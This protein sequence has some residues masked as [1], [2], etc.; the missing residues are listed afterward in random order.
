MLVVTA[1]L[2]RLLLPT[3]T[4]APAGYT[5]AVPQLAAGDGRRVVELTFRPP[6]LITGAINTSLYDATTRNATP[7]GNGE[8]QVLNSSA[9]FTQNF[10]AVDEDH[11]FGQLL[12]YGGNFVAADGENR[13]Y[14]MYVYSSD[15]NP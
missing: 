4:S 7:A 13:G 12:W 6:S 15:G 8:V 9:T 1:A 14:S 11:I 3:A 10:F 5:V 2:L